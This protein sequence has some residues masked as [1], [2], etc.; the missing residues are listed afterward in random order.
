MYPT[1][2]YV[3]TPSE[4]QRSISNAP[5]SLLSQTLGAQNAPE[6]ALKHGVISGTLVLGLEQKCLHGCCGAL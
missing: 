3:K 4:K 1:N 2:W 5:L 6:A